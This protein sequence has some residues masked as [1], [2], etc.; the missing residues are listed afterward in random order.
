[1]VPIICNYKI[2]R[3]PL[4]YILFTLIL[5]VG[6]LFYFRVAHHFNIVDKPNERSSHKETTIR[7][8]GVVYLIAA[9]IVLV[10]NSQY[11]L[12]IVSMLI[13][14]TVSFI[15]DRIT[16]SNKIRIIFHLT[17][18]TIV[19]YALNIFGLYT[20]PLVFILY[21][22]VVGVINA[23]NFMDGI[24]GMTGV[25]SLVVLLGLQY[26]NLKVVNYVDPGMIWMPILASGVFLYFNFR[27]K[28]RCF[29]GDVGS[30]TIALWI[31]YLLLKLISQTNDLTYLFFLALYGVDSIL[32]ILHRLFLRQNIFKA[33]RMHFY[34]VL[35]NETGVPHLLVSCMYGFIQASI[36][37]IIIFYQVTLL[38][39][40]FCVIVPL[41]II[42]I[43]LKPRLMKLGISRHTYLN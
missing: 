33:H 29:A 34:Q 6:M 23:Y 30:I 9:L 24:N 26:V 13:I 10:T 3:K 22:F 4:M 43:Y 2:K 14:G 35:A 19:F 15:D 8:G 25:H 21:I 31:S 32:T 20:W 38:P 16:L 1:M 7:G 18:L 12:P 27:T 36:I 41:V 40:I 17:S 42:Y 11:Y 37:F 39:L 28:A 5:L